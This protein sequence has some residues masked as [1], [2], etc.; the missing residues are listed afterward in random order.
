MN[1]IPFLSI[2][3]MALGCFTVMFVTFLAAKKTPEVWAFL[4]VLADCILW[5]GG[6]ILMRMQMWPGLHFWYAVSLVAL[7][8]MELLFYN[9]VH[10]FTRER[11]R[12]LLLVFTAWTLLLVPGTISGFFLAAPTPFTRADGATLFTYSL[13]WHIILPC[14]MFVAIIIATTARLLRIMREQGTH[15]PGIQILVSG[16]LIMLVGNLLQV[17]LPGNT[18]PFDALA[19]IGFAVL[20]MYA[21][22]K[23]RV[24]RMTLVVSRTLL[25]VSLAAICVVGSS[26]VIV[27]LKAFA[28]GQLKL[29]EAT[30]T[31]L[32]AL[33]F[34]ALLGVAYW[35]MS[36]LMGA[37][38]TREEQQNRLVKK[39]SEEI[40]Q[41]LSTAE[42]MEKVGTV[43]SREISTEQIYICLLEDGEYKARYCTSP[44]ATLSFSIS[45]DSPQIAYLRDQESYFLLGEFR[46]NPL[47]LS[48]W[49]SEKD[50]FR[51]LNIDCVTAM[52]DG[53]E[54]VGLLLLSAKDRG[55][56]FN[57]AEIG[58]LQTVNS[59]AS[60]AMKN[61]ALY[62][63]IFREARIDPLTD[64][65]NYRYFVE[66]LEKQFSL[67]KQ[68]CL[69][70][71]Y[72]DADDFKLYNQLYGVG[73]GDQA[74]C[75]IGEAIS[76]C[77]G[78]SGT[79][80]RTSG[81][82]FAVLLPRQDT[83]QA[84]IMARE[85]EDRVTDINLAPE[86][87]QFKPLTV[88]IGICSAP[89]AAST[90]KEL[91]D[92]AD[93]A[94]YNAKQGG[95]AQVVV[96]R[97][98]SGAGSQQLAERT[99]AIV[100]RIERGD[101]EYRNALSL[102]SALTAA[103]D[104]KDHYTYAHSKNV[105]R[106]AAS[107]AVAAGLNDDQVRTIYAAGLLH[108]IGK[109]SV[110]ES[111][112]NKSGRLDEAE[113]H[114]IQDHVNNSVEMIRHLPEVDYLIPAA[115]G[116]HERWDG[117]GYPRGISGE[118]IPV[119][120]RCLAIA[121]VFDAMTTDR[122]YRQGLSLDYALSELEKGEG[123]QFDPRLSALF[124]TLVRER[125]IP[126]STQAASHLM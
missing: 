27:P 43:V 110:P 31:T 64:L 29:S 5:S 101:G 85:I 89:L 6:S 94:V 30:A 2:N 113:Y 103:I 81:K 97:G 63:K 70:L 20:L 24:F 21:L 62:E 102:I 68:D 61:A 22:Y 104:A 120:A 4:A 106:Y 114:V 53:N 54:I 122:P 96:F 8:S 117:K 71:L 34:A 74:L 13:N 100:D 92:N 98:A 32:V 78:Q 116:H 10:I 3:I 37:V 1:N 47:Y 75:R 121:D 33:T 124:V 107:L 72:I 108:D 48:V 119:S 57:Q 109:I 50:L 58:F 115:L 67:C 69:T 42:V 60:I 23:R 18:F 112:L 36:Q 44:L 93:L 49:E 77:V 19:G 87:R 40:N 86:R 11:G 39:F 38:F 15:A 82:V 25:A 28:E 111:I 46:N 76:R 95:K 51:R 73:E 84:Q 14:V 56:S 125:S 118:E 91:M 9:F 35:L 41:S 80:F 65:Y 88:S 26:Y 83:R 66:Q 55:R 123:T 45:K 99:D 79:A 90:A 59:I 52:R 126:L 105:A 17:G 7:F 16:G 12:F